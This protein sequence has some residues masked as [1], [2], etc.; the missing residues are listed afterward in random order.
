MC[1]P[2]RPTRR[3]LP[4]PASC[5]S[6]AVQPCRNGAKRGQFWPVERP[7]SVARSPRFARRFVRGLRSP[8]ATMSRASDA[9]TGSVCSSLMRRSSTWFAVCWPKSAS[10]TAARA[11]CRASRSSSWTRV[12]RSGRAPQARA[13]AIRSGMC[14]L[15]AAAPTSTAKPIMRRR[16]RPWVIR[17]VPLTPSSGE[18]PRRS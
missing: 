3:W 1:A 9:T 7:D 4:G 17:T 5:G 12:G 2:A 18:P 10:K 8:P 11:S 14:A 6:V 13:S 16:A 15:A